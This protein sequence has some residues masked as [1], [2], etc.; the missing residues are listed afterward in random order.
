MT[1]N[2][3][4]MPPIMAHRASLAN[5]LGRSGRTRGP[6]CTPGSGCRR[7][8]R[9]AAQRAADGHR[10]ATPRLALG[11][12]DHVAEQH[13]DRGR[14]DA[15]DARRDVARRPLR[16]A[17]RRRAAACGP[18]S[19]PRRRP[20]PHPGEMCSGCRIPGTPAAATTISA[21]CVYSRPVGHAGVHDGHRRVRGRALLRQQHRERP[22][23]RRAP[24]E[25]AHLM[26]RDRDLVVREQRLDPRGRARHRARASTARAGHV[27][28]VQPVDVLVR[29]DLEQRGLVVDLR[30]RRV[31]DED[32]R[33]RPGRR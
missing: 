13:R 21:R 20:R 28:R 25:D 6:R 8:A 31:L 10:A 19:A 32:S 5:G 1:T 11:R 27:H 3:A 26:A 17:R 33:R 24:P 23:E 4:A 15:A 12:F 16:S 30:R 9:A 18:R 7:R 29:V 2:T 22:A 14:A